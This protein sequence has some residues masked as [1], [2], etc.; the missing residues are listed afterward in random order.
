MDLTNPSLAWRQFLLLLIFSKL[1]TLA[2]LPYCFAR[3]TQFFSLP[4]VLAWFFKATKFVP[5][6]SVEVFRKDPFL[7]L[8]FSLFLPIIFLLFCL[9][10]SA[11]LF[12]QMTSFFVSSPPR[13][14]LPHRPLKEL[15]FDWCTGL[16]TDVFLSILENVRLLSLQWTV[17]LSSLVPPLF[18]QLPS[19][20][21]SHTNFS[22]GYL[23]SQ[24]FL[25]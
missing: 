6:G 21:Q 23:R 4:G 20:F 17:L 10:P 11:A 3:W 9:F 24:S 7:A 25:F 14:L 5:F 22:C 15:W 19:A 8:Y 1:S 12:M 18:I 2:G 13:Y 16:S